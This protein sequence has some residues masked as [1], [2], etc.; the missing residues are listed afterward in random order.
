MR[1]VIANI[2]NYVGI[3]VI[4]IGKWIIYISYGIRGE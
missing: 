3:G 2:F 4:V 1:N